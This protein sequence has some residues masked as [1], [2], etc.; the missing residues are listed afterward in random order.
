MHLH[1]RRR[2]AQEGAKGNLSAL[3]TRHPA[4]SEVLKTVLPSLPLSP[5]K[6]DSVSPHFPNHVASSYSTGYR[7]VSLPPPAVQPFACFTEDVKHSPE[8]EDLVSQ[9]ATSALWETHDYNSSLVPCGYARVF[10][11]MGSTARFCL[12]KQVSSV[13]AGV[14]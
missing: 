10:L 9:G 11:G 1:L 3:L 8:S 12:N 14:S 5:K 2:Q 13:C 6:Q 7:A 4:S